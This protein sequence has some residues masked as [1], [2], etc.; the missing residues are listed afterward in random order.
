M[1]GKQGVS[2]L[3]RCQAC[4]ELQQFLNYFGYGYGT[5]PCKKGE[6][7]ISLFEHRGQHRH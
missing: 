3:W 2:L 4:Q 7:A 5:E 6:A 1:V